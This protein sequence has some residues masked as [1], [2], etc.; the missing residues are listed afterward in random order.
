[1]P[2]QAGLNYFCIILDDS[3]IGFLYFFVILHRE[4]KLLTKV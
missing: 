1:M 4:F 2:F 3:G